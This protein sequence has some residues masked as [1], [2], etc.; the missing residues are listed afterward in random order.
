MRREITPVQDV[1][2]KVVSFQSFGS[3]ASLILF[4]FSI[5]S[6]LG[7]ITWES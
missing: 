7:N 2:V 1:T 3:F 4:C 5:C 6:C